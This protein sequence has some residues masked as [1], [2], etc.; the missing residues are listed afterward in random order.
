[1]RSALLPALAAFA[2]AARHQNFAHAAEELHLTASAVSHH[3]RKLELALGVSLFQRHAR[4]VV[5]TPEGRLLA[6]AA[7][8]ALGEIESVL[9]GLRQHRRDNG[10]RITILPSLSA[11]WLTPRLRR[12]IDLHPTIRLSVDTDRSLVRFDEGGPDLGIRYGL[13]QWPG[14]TSRFLMDDTLQPLASPE[15]AAKVAQA[16]D[17]ATL[18]LLTDIAPEG[19]R[20]WFKAAGVRYPRTGTMHTISDSADGLN[21]AASGLGAVLARTRLAHQ[22]I[23]DG[24]LVRLP[25]PELPTRY[26]YYVVHSA[27]RPPTPAALSFIAW[28]EREALEP[29]N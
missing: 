7:G 4:G 23:A 27:H 3:V 2:S 29:R 25:G 16:G 18:P 9:D 20:E 21:A 28:L 22:H 13:G 6:D 19:W 24:R 15:L 26:A 17:V 12:F 5:L 8:S 10:L 14:L 11:N 1:M